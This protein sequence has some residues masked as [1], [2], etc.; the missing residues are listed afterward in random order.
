MSLV[1]ISF[2]YKLSSSLKAR[3]NL[4]ASGRQTPLLAPFSFLKMAFNPSLLSNNSSFSFLDALMF[5][6]SDVIFEF[7][8]RLKTKT[9]KNSWRY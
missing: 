6:L 8:V 2:F 9:S 3:K 1:V 7:L 4:T 5:F